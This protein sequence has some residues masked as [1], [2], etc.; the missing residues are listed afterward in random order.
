VSRAGAE[1]RKGRCGRLGPGLCL[2]LYTEADFEAR[3]P[4]TEPEILRTNLAAL[5]LR[6]AADGLGAAEDFPFIDPPDARARGD[7]YRLLQELQALDAD[8]RITSRGR[9]MS[10]LPL[11]PRLARALLESKRYR[12]CAELLAIVAGLSVPDIR[13]AASK[14]SATG[15]AEDSSLNDL[16]EDSKSEFSALVKVWKAYRAAREGPRRELRR[17]CKERRFSLLRLSE[18]D[19]VYSQVADRAAEVGLVA[20]RQAASYGG[21]HRSLLAG[22]G[23]MVGM[24]GEDGV[25]LGTRGIGFHIF[26]GSPLARRR[27][28]WIM[29]ANIVETSRV[30]ARRVAEIEPQW[31]EAAAS[32]LLRREYLEPDW[33]E[34]REQVTARERV[35]FLGLTLSAN[36]A[37]NYGPI[38]PEESRRI[39][40]R[41]ALVYQRL[42]RRPDWL[43]ANDAAI[44]DA[45]RMEER[46]RT[47][48]LVHGAEVFVD[49][50]DGALPRQVS[51]AATLEH[52]TRHL[53][54]A[55]RAALTL[56]PERIFAR[57]PEPEALSRYPETAQVDSLAVPVEYH[58]APGES[59]DGASLRIPVLALP[60]LTR[61]AVDAAVPGFAEPRIEALLRSLPKDARRNL[62]PIG[63]T[64]AQFLASTHGRT[65]MARAADAETLKVWLKETRGIPESQLRFDLAAVPAHLIPQLTVIADGR[66]VAHGAVLAE[67]RRASAAAAAAELARHAEAAYA[68]LGSWQR[69][70]LDTLPDTVPLVS[71]QG[72]VWV[73]P[74]LAQR[75]PSQ[76]LE[77]RYEWSAAEARRCWRNGAAQLARR[78]LAAQ[79]RDLGR[80]ISG[81]AP[82][83]LAAAP[84]VK[85]AALSDMLLQMVFR[86]ACFADLDAPRS[87]DAF[88]RAVEQ[89]RAQLHACLEE[90]AAGALLWF[91][92]ARAIRRA[93]EM[94]GL[95]LAADAAAESLEHLQR[96]LNPA[97]LESLAPE[98][99]RQLPRY[100]KAEARRWQ[101]A[102]ARGIESP[103][104]LRE[105]RSWSER[106][107]S[108]S[109]ELGAELRWIPELDD[110]QNWIEEYRVSLYAQ[111]LRTLGPVSAARLESRAAEIENWI[112]R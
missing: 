3:P 52:F 48:D 72:T 47:R 24:R 39:F 51:S 22:F 98:W 88:D 30:F 6:L 16:L 90:I 108:L 82:L 40:A 38:A 66:E 58:F 74:T 83:L 105:L 14:S 36:R 9:I 89:G 26:P 103:H 94:Q 112:R 20:Q 42:S 34:D 69:F 107:R 11:D 93:L 96:L 37:V 33:D 87:R 92:E 76:V 84:F 5:L 97:A 55:A 46:L 80:T 25:Y 100:L 70:E 21:V 79:A 81:N 49:F 41:E 28:R 18:W 53:S 104:I 8:R 62:I 106:C 91:N 73:Y 35:S 4:F 56:G 102:A 78:M 17:W 10:R 23:T 1:Q 110:L 67:L 63:E 71:E 64:A 109:V 95:K 45:L 65:G 77:V 86:R 2:R 15:A 19:N 68:R 44:R 101:R 111:E 50:Y 29:A 54:A 57:M 75:P 31:I 61:A 43:Q 60:G 85:S 7:G 59:R 99:L 12:A 27:P 13:M 32:H